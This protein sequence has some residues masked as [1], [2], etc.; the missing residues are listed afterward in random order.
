M[1]GVLAT[2][3]WGAVNP[4]NQLQAAETYSQPV[5]GEWIAVTERTVNPYSADEA[6]GEAAYGDGR[7][8]FWIIGIL[9]NLSVLALFLVWAVRE[10]RK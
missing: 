5:S 7:T 10:W 2:T 8:G 9:V 1:M 3:A 6:S 4:T